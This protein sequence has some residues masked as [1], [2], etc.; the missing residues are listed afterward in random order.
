MYT[1]NIHPS[2]RT[3]PAQIT[4]IFGPMPP[5]TT[6]DFGVHER[7]GRDLQYWD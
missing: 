1:T 2:C 4:A 7:A 5:L 3:T 6:T